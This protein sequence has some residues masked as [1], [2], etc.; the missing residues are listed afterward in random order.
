[1][2]QSYLFPI[3]YAFM[4]FPVAAL[5]FTLPF[6]IVQYRKHG[7]INKIRALV[8]YLLLLYLMNAFYLVLLPMPDSR[9]N[10]QPS[11]HM[12]QYVPLGFIQEI[13]ANVTLSVED[14]STFLSLLREPA[15]LQAAFNVALTIPFG[16]FLGY[17]FR[18][19][20][21]VCLLLSFSL[22][23][24]FEITQITGIYGFF[25]HPYRIFDVDDLITNTLGGLA[26]YRI[27]LWI[28]GL[29][30]RIEQL[31]SQVNLSAKAVSYTRRGIAF[32][33]DGCLSGAGFIVLSLSSLSVLEAYGITIAV[34]FLLIPY[35]SNGRMPGKWIVRIRVSG[36]DERIRLRELIFRYGML[37]GILGGMNIYMLNAS[38]V[39][40][41]DSSWLA[42]LP[43]IVLLMDGMFSLHLITRKFKKDH[44]LF[45]ERL[46]QTRNT[47]IWP[48]KQ[49]TNDIPPHQQL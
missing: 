42:A 40:G 18:A 22:S 9:H 43:G 7:Y 36:S 29:L 46:S 41:Y 45:Y 31:D 44:Q 2:F 15:F 1:M 32:M 25:D 21:V 48:E 47:I 3:T 14:P 11:I 6:L 16:L 49:Q 17:Y 35:L 13:L 27:A 4:T 8:L 10:I 30:P 28:S 23:L 34:Y 37:Y 26:G 33:V 20:R 39:Q 24:C 5:L 38:A 12:I 19:R